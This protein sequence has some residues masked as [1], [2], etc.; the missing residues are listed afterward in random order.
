[1]GYNDFTKERAYE[2]WTSYRD[3]HEVADLMREQ[4]PGKCK[5][6]SYETIRKWRD[7]MGSESRLE[8]ALDEIRAD[9]DKR[10]VGQITQFQYDLRDHLQGVNAHTNDVCLHF[11]VGLPLLNQLLEFKESWGSV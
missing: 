6:L 1:M 10:V 9:T 8:K 4:Y 7:R 5:T 3:I 2:V 11:G